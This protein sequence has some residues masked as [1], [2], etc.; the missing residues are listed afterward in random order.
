MQQRH[1]SP[2][3]NIQN[4][5]TKKY[6]TID[7]RPWNDR[8]VCGKTSASNWYIA[9]GDG[10][11]VRYEDFSGSVLRVSHINARID[12]CRLYIQNTGFD[13]DLTGHGDPAPGTVSAPITLHRSSTAI[14]YSASQSGEI[15]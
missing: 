4:V 6:L 12:M 2:T 1:D 10:N 5:E 14:I 3:Y 13:M 15:I 11:H 8:T 9:A 7:G